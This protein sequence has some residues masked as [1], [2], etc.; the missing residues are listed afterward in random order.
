MI[1]RDVSFK[2]N[3]VKVTGLK[4]IV[5]DKDT[6]EFDALFVVGKFSERKVEVDYPKDLLADST[7]KYSADNIKESDSRI[8]LK[9]KSKIT[10]INDKENPNDDETI[11]AD[12][13]IISLK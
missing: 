3:G 13:I 7:L 2:L 4:L 5:V 1:G 9:G 12:E 6:R 8:I 11:E 10:D